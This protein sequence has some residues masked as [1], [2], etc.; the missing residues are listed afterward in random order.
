[1]THETFTLRIFPTDTQLYNA[2]PTHLILY[3]FCRALRVLLAVKG[4]HLYCASS[5]G[6]HELGCWLYHS[7]AVWG[8]W[9]QV[10]NTSSS[11]P[12][13]E[14]KGAETTADCPAAHC[15]GVSGRWWLVTSE[16]GST[17]SVRTRNLCAG[18][19]LQ[20]EVWPRSRLGWQE[21]PH[22]LL[23]LVPCLRGLPLV[24][25]PCSR[26]TAITSLWIFLKHLKGKS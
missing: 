7:S 22:A 21:D 3:P 24:Y 26:V 25:V 13:K 6:K 11:K 23:P 18:S 5:I 14:R 2:F 12:H 16:G 19:V 20:G 17:E 15:E 1:M 8:R 4:Q 9:Q 10:I